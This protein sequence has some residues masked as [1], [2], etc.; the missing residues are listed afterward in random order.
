ME[1]QTHSE[2]LSMTMTMPAGENSSRKNHRLLIVDDDHDV[3]RALMEVS[4]TCGYE[5]DQAC[6]VPEALLY[7]EQQPYTCILTDLIMPEKSGLD[8]LR[9]VVCESSGCCRHPRR[10][11]RTTRRS[12]SSPEE[13]CV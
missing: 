8:P 10:A 2:P 4:K 3:R 5:C 6:S 1:S 13:W 9:D 12:A 7:L 11:D